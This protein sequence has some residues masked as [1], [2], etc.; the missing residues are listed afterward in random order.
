[1]AMNIEPSD[2][3]QRGK[4]LDT[5]KS[6]IVQALGLRTEIDEFIPNFYYSTK[7]T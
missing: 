1:M 6:F 5:K 4:A 3:V 7:S 2:H